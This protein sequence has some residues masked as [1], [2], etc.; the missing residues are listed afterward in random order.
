MRVPPRQNSVHSMLRMRPR[1]SYTYSYYND[2]LGIAFDWLEGG[3]ALTHAEHAMH[4]V[5]TREDAHG[6]RLLLSRQLASGFWPL[7]SFFMK[8]L[9]H[10]VN[11]CY[12]CAIKCFKIRGCDVI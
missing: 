5:L 4:T 2:D 7:P 6:V 11:F 9:C 8:I 10:I 12:L 3:R 1:A